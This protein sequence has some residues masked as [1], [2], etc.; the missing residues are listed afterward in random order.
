VDHDKEEGQ[1]TILET[2]Q[3][4]L[5]FPVPRAASTACEIN[6]LKLDKLKKK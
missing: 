3:S 2:K 1:L 4:K 5:S 6:K